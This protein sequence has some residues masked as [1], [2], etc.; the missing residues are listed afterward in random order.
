MKAGFLAD[1]AELYPDLDDT[2]VVVWAMH[3]VKE[4]M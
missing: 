3:Q 4:P 1:L 2:A